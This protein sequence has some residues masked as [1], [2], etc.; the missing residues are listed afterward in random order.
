MWVEGHIDHYGS[1]VELDDDDGDDDDDD[2]DDDI[3]QYRLVI[4]FNDKIKDYAT[5]YV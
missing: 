3:R 5:Q 1:K 4:N 2:D